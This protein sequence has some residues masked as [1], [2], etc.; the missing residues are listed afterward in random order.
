MT[1]TAGPD[2]TLI[3]AELERLLH[4]IC[5]YEQFVLAMDTRLDDIPGIDSLRLLEAVAHLEEHFHVEVDVELLNYLF[6]AG[7]IVDAVARAQP[8]D[9]RRE[10][11]SA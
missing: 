10:A 2:P 11:R 7:D 4:R 1:I 3:F 6:R 9:N 5:E 8:M